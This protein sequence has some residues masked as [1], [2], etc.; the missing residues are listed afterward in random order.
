MLEFTDYCW[1]IIDATATNA[2]AN[3]YII[4]LPDGMDAVPA[5]VWLNPITFK[6]KGL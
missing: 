2:A 3:T 5:Q 6:Q 4:P 1:N